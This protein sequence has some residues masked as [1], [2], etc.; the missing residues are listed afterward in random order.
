[1]KDLPNIARVLLNLSL[2]RSFDYRIPEQL[3]GRIT[4]G[5]R[6]I[7]PF[8]RGDG[9]RRAYVVAVGSD[10]RHGDL[11]EVIAV[12]EDHPA[13]P[14]SL[15]KIGEWMADYYCCAGELAVRT[16]LPGAVRSG[17]IKPKTKAFYFLNDMSRAADYIAKN[18]RARSKCAVIRTL[19]LHPGIESEALESESGASKAVLKE[20]VKLDLVTTEDRA[21][22]RNPFAG[23]ELL[24]TEPLPPTDEQAAALKVMF[25][26]M[27]HPESAAPHVILL[28]GVTGSGKTEVY[29][30]AIARAV[31]Q[32][33]E[34]IV[35]VPEISLT[36]QTVE[37][38][39]SRFG[40]MVSVLHSGLTDGERYDEWMKVH[41]G[42][43]KIA[44]GARSALFA[45]F[46][47]LALII[48]DEEH[49]TS[50][51][52]SE[53]PRYNARDVAVMRGKLENALVILG[54][55]TPSME[56]YYNAQTGKYTLCRLTKRSDPSIL[57]P[58]VK[59]IDMRL[60][61]TEEGKLPFLSKFLVQAVRERIAR[62][63]Q[64]I[65]FLNRRGFARQMACDL[66][67][68]V[69]MCPDCS[70][71]Y[72]YHRKTQMLTCHLC[73]SSREAPAVCPNCGSEHIRYSG[74]GTE[75]IENISLDCFKGA[76]IARMDSDSMTRPSLYA[77]VLSQFRRGELDILIG[78]Q[79]IAKGL[80]FPNVTLVG[81]VNADM[82][83]F[84]PDFRAA[85]RSFQLLTQVAG[86]AGR[87][88]VKG[89]VLVQTC[90]PFNPPL[91]YAAGHD[92][93]GF[94]REEIAIREEL[95]YPPFGHMMIVH[96]RGEDP[97]GILRTAAELMEKVRPQLDPE[98]IV[99]E[100]A[101]APIERVKGKYRFMAAFRSGKLAPLRRALRREIYSV[102]RP[103]VEIYVDVDPISML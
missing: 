10:S 37:R 52:Q 22:E 47:N 79:M 102:R 64:S 61:G 2:D 68:Y 76:R 34:A 49:D 73:A 80:H 8:G 42:K 72:T 31:E 70:V 21:V 51:K 25:E 86:R 26:R 50:Y 16:L 77:K 39:R 55:A 63:E 43:V 6:V 23:T 30:Q 3:R 1:M 98:T 20:L 27:E 12:C 36:P 28:H 69:A 83:L 95:K 45:P 89:E 103:D 7:V 41:R 46:R 75:R 29:L 17:K 48:V 4:A 57:M 62:G 87:G 99:S 24:R 84:M 9:E 92:Y 56:S 11:K 66:C 35:L 60:E 44:V 19:M 91:M 5:M 14:Q 93:E 97:E 18:A 88:E 71:A 40:D 54:S 65:L 33:R 96:F 13:L 94:Y 58:E 15:L 82:G 101:P 81:I 74:A 32:G 67:G 53:A 38:F 90:T 59:I 85:E 78:T 100:P